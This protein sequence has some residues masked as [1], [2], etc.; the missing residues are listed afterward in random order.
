MNK[1]LVVIPTYN[2]SGNIEK[3]VNK[4]LSLESDVDVLIVDD[5]SPDGTGELADM[6]AKKHQEVRVIHRPAKLGMGRA[7]VDGF[8]WSMEKGYE[9]VLEMDADF[10][11][12]PEDLKR[13]L[14]GMSECDVCIGSRYTEGAG[15]V[16]WSIWREILSRSANVYVKLITR[17]P[18]ADG[19]A[20]FKCYKMEVL[21]AIDVDSV[22]SE[23]YAFQIEMHYKSWKKGFH[24][25]EIPIT[26]TERRQGQSKMSKKIVFEAFFTVWRLIFERSGRS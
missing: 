25:K 23:G 6:L 21:K 24:L 1:A 12:D 15:I 13:L 22:R 19:T 20:G 3:I 16:N 4:V 14:S 9:Y 10:S 5:N 17:M 18:I 2:E 7:Y 11:H 26:F 8:K